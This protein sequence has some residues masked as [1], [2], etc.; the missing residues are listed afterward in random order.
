MYTAKNVI[1]LY[2]Y[3]NLYLYKIIFRAFKN[4][5]INSFIMRFQ[6]FCI[7][8]GILLLRAENF[9]IK[10]IFSNIE[11]FI[12]IFYVNLRDLKRFVFIA[13]NNCFCFFYIIR[14]II[15]HIKSTFLE[16]SKKTKKDT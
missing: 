5:Y 9:I 3:K 11:F 1:N 15:I 13:I 8:S 7:F 14:S 4:K 16:I 2:N 10:C 6:K 12:K